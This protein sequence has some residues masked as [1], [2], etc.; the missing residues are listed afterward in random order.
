VAAK[1]PKRTRADADEGVRACMDLMADGLWVSGKSHADI[2]ARF[3]VAPATVKDWATS[4]SRVLRLAVEGDREDLRARLVTTLENVVAE[5][6]RTVKPVV[7]RSIVR[8]KVRQ[9]TEML[10][11]PSLSAAVEAVATQGRLLG[12]ITSKVDVTTR[13]SVAH[14]SREEHA[15]E[16]AKLSA[17]IAAE[18]ARLASEGS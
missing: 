18:Q 16:L 9:V 17:E 3:G 6:M 15:A 2:A 12:L 8:G 4:A 5:A 13:P 10:P 7:V 14:L 1:K 11:A